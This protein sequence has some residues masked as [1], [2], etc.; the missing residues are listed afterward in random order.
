MDFPTCFLGR[1]KYTFLIDPVFHPLL[2]SSL[3][4]TSSKLS[5]VRV[6][7]P[8]FFLLIW[9]GVPHVRKGRANI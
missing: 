2:L 3:W 7:I 5:L 9:I 1:N 8:S 6:K 4:S